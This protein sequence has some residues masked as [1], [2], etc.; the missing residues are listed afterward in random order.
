MS[1]KINNSN[2]LSIVGNQDKQQHVIFE[3][4]ESVSTNDKILSD[5]KKILSEIGFF[6]NDFIQP[7]SAIQVNKLVL[8]N[9]DFPTDYAKIKQIK[10]ELIVRYHSIIESYYTIKKKE[11]E[12]KLLDDEIANE[13]HPIKK[14]L[15]VLDNEKAALQLM[16]EKS[17]LNV[18]LTE[19]RIYY[20][21]YIKYNTGFENLSDEQKESLEEEFWNK[22][23]LNN[24]V[25]F[26][27][28][29]GDFIKEILGDKMYEK[30]LGRRKSKIG[31]FAREL[32]NDI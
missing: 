14:E 10:T 21:Y 31:L 11:L 26:E 30:Y 29:Y 20:K 5:D 15:K 6:Q 16:A 22:K 2:T 23:A 18:I 9:I 24:P 4:I 7:I 3:I 32:I 25:V 17:K 27:E 12:I 8:N 28:R 19:L 13:H 1:E